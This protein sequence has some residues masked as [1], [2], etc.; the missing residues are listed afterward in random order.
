MGKHIWDD[1]LKVSNW[2]SLILTSNSSHSFYV[3][4]DI[5][6]CKFWI[7]CI[8]DCDVR[9]LSVLWL[10][11]D[12]T[13]SAPLLTDDA[14]ML[15]MELPPSDTVFWFRENLYLFWYWHFHWSLTYWFSIS[16]SRALSLWH[17]WLPE[18]F[19]LKS[20]RLTKSLRYVVFFT[21]I[22]GLLFCQR[23]FNRLFSNI[24][25]DL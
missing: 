16:W 12:Y 1:E 21:R 2:R 20:R 4:R 22:I 6:L 8:P 23:A 7:S 13:A 14:L 11:A 24:G 3:S 19:R 15:C 17:F 9:R 18:W 5:V 25:N 10:I